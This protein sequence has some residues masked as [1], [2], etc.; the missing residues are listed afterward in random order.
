M[1][2]RHADR[3]FK[4]QNVDVLSYVALGMLIFMIA[5]ACFFVWFLGGLPGRVAADRNHPYAKSIQVGG[6]ASMCLGIVTWPIILMWAYADSKSADPESDVTGTDT[7]LRNEI[8]QLKLQVEK[9]SRTESQ[10]G[11]ANG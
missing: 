3:D 4:E 10:P 1:Q 5:L 8:A 6:W 11:E 7:D 9:L 2:R